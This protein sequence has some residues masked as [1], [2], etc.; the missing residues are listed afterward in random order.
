MFTVNPNLTDVWIYS[1]RVS[2]TVGDLV[3]IRMNT[4]HGVSIHIPFYTTDRDGATVETTTYKT[5]LKYGFSTVENTS[6]GVKLVNIP[7]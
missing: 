4:D 7:E 2:S 5:F 3:P 1:T 6:T